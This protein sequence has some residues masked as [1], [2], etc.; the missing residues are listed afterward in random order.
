LR[1]PARRS[2]RIIGVELQ[3][4]GSA[5]DPLAEFS[6]DLTA[7]ELLAPFSPAEI[8]EVENICD[9][10]PQLRA[11][12]SANTEQASAASTSAAALEIELSAE[13]IDALLES[14]PSAR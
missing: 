10:D 12:S 1:V 2:G 9:V 3:N 4:E 7:Q 13:D 14:G 11:L 5:M 8:V 6:I